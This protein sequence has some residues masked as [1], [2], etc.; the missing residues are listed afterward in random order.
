M[1]HHHSALTGFFDFLEKINR[2]S[3]NPTDG[4]FPLR[5]TESDLNQ[6]IN[7]ETAYKLLKSVDRT[8]WIGQRNFTP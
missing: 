6:P 7:T 4:L 8:S 5:R 2:I 3:E 1:N